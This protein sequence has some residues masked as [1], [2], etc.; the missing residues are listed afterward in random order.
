MDN[1][2]AQIRLRLLSLLGRALHWRPASLA[3]FISLHPAYVLTYYSP[4][5]YLRFPLIGH[6]EGYYLGHGSWDGVEAVF[7]SHHE[8]P[9]EYTVL[10]DEDNRVVLDGGQDSASMVGSIFEFHARDIKLHLQAK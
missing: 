7:Q 4:T 6:L 5:A 2:T 9:P 10:L 1:S 3:V 8:F